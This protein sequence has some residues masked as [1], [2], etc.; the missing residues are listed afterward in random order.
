MDRLLPFLASFSCSLEEA[1][2]SDN[3]MARE[4]E[5]MRRVR[6]RPE[7]MRQRERRLTK[8]EKD[9]E[10]ELSTEALTTTESEEEEKRQTEV[11][12]Q[13]SFVGR[14]LGAMGRDLR[15]IAERPSGKL[16]IRRLEEAG[17]ELSEVNRRESREIYRRLSDLDE[18]LSEDFIRRESE[19]LGERLSE[20]DRTE[21]E[22]LEEIGEMKTESAGKM[23]KDE[24]EDE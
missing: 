13:G 20:V 23:E 6:G 16:S 19:E 10:D 4:K 21:S 8:S 7:K 12:E 5:S 24:N 11:G 1:P 2:E 15:D 9:T 18:K 17:M 14:E 22:E 3:A